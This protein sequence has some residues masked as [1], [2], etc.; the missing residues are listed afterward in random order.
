LTNALPKIPVFLCYRQSDG[1][2]TARRVHELLHKSAVE[3]INLETNDIQEH[4]LDVYYDQTSAVNDDWTRIHEP[5]LKRARAFILVCTPGAYIN[6]GDDDW[7]QKELGWW[8][9]S[10]RNSPILI[11]AL[12]SESRYVPKQIAQRWPNA[13]RVKL[14]SDEWDKLSVEQLDREKQRIKNRILNGISVESHQWLKL[15][16]QTQKSLSQK[17]NSRLRLA[18]LGMALA[19]GF[20]VFSI[21]KAIEADNQRGIAEQKRIEADK[22]VQKVQALIDRIDF[23]TSD[24]AGVKSM[25]RICNE[26]IDTSKA[27]ANPIRESA[28]VE[29]LTERFWQLY[30]GEMN[31]VEL[32]EMNINGYSQIDPTMKSFGDALRTVAPDSE[33][34]FYRELNVFSENIEVACREFISQL[35]K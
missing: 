27:L 22:A 25:D 15:E 26:A 19:V 6:E 16:L 4:Q 10:N 14:V 29:L 2:D 31:L 20:G 9:E 23:G 17:L 18:V 34:E 21:S 33:P 24:A 13:Q 8:L 1:S 7:V 32:R 30:Y 3:A 12:G 11:D 35:V 5:Y 28:N